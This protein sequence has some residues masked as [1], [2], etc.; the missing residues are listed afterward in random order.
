MPI[1]KYVPSW[2]PGAGFKR[3]AKDAKNLFDS[4]LH[5]SFYKVKEEF[6][7]G[8]HFDSCMSD[9]NFLVLQSQG[10][11]NPSFVRHALELSQETAAED[12]IIMSAACSLMNGKL[13]RTF[14][15]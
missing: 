12:D 4:S 6:V 1:V 13:S 10:L 9:D 15:A 5:T 14:C 11:A 8:S 3:W 7:S 2:V